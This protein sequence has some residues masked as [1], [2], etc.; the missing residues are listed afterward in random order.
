MPW[1]LRKWWL[2]K[3]RYIKCLITMQNL[4]VLCHIVWWRVGSHKIGGT[5][6]RLI[7]MGTWLTAWNMPL[8]HVYYHAQFDRCWSSGTSVCTEIRQKYWAPRVPPFKLTQV[9]QTS[10]TDRSGILDFLFV[11][12]RND[13]PTYWFRDKPRF[14][15][16]KK[17]ILFITVVH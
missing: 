5:C 10:D 1:V 13:G 7:G 16:G 3:R 9:H 11:I 14:R 6:A 15:S 17:Q 4:A 8:S 12:H 2:T